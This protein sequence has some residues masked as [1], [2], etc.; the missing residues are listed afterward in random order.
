V[1]SLCLALDGEILLLLTFSVSLKNEIQ[2]AMIEICPR[3]KGEFRSIYR[4]GWDKE[5]HLCVVVY[6]FHYSPSIHLCFFVKG[7]LYSWLQANHSF[8]TI[9]AIHL[10]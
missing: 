1:N 2:D 4:G 9:V 8:D 6:E 5:E 10:F 3:L 7:N